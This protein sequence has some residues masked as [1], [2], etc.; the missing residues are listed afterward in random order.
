MGII[1]KTHTHTHTYS[2]NDA[3]QDLKSVGSG[4][5]PWVE[6]EVKTRPLLTAR[7]AC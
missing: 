2:R 5:S 3:L 6:T 7:A 4:G 1:L